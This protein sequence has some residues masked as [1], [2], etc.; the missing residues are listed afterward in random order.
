MVDPSQ[1]IESNPTSTKIP[2]TAIGLALVLAA[3]GFSVVAGDVIP[4]W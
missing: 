4:G 3:I 1:P 2:Q